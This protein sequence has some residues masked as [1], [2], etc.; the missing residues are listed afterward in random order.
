MSGC[1]AGNLAVNRAIRTKRI[2]GCAT[3]SSTSR[4]AWQRLEINVYQYLLYPKIMNKLMAV[5]T[6]E[7]Q[8]PDA[9]YHQ[10]EGLATQLHLTIPELLCKA[11]EQMLQQQAKARPKANGHWQFPEGHHLGTFLTP[12][13][14]WRLLANEAAD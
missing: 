12:V 11:A 3:P 4:P 6:T 5:K 9:I 13:E 10:V 14:D 7:V 2:Y 8:L 1:H